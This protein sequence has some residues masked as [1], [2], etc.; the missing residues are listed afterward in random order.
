MIIPMNHDCGTCLACADACPAGA[1]KG[2][3]EDFD[4]R[5]CYETLKEFRSKGFTTQFICG[6]CV[7]DCRGPKP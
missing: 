5:A 1:I 6:I 7:R 3:R 4:H 2:S